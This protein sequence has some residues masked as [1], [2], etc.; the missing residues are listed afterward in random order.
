[1]ATDRLASYGSLARFR[2]LQR[3][4]EL[5]NS[6]MLGSSGDIA[7]FQH[8]VRMLERYRI[9]EACEDDGHVLSPRQWFTALSAHMYGKR[10]KMDPLWNSHVVAGVDPKTGDR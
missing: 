3:I 6:T 1:M 8:T 7:D 2:D 9:S 5:G 4:V 10:T